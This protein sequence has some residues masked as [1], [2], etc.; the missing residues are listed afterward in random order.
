MTVDERLSELGIVLPQV[1]P[2]VGNYLACTRTGDLL[3][4]GGHGPVDGANTIVGKVGTDITLE[5]GR[6]AARMT[7]LSILAT[8]QAE[9][10]SLDRVEQFVKVFGMVNV[11]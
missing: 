6:A 5:E 8:M 11:G 7:G 10:G 3:F 9:L 4:V 2:P 1:F